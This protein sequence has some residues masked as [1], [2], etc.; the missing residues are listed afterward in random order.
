MT[1]VAHAIESELKRVPGTR[2]VTT[3]GGTQ[4]VVRV[5]LNPESLNAF[6]L[7]VQDVR[8]TLQSANVSQRAGVLTQNNREVLVQTGGFLNNAGDVKQLVVGVFN[9]QPV[10]VRDIAEVRDGAD[11]PTS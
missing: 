3:V 4:R 9:A 7:T 10:F 8:A 5:Q 6:Q 11:Q 2:E 1:Q